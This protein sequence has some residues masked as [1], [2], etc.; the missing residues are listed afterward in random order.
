[1]VDAECGLFVAAAVATTVDGVGTAGNDGGGVVH[2]TG[3]RVDSMWRNAASVTLFRWTDVDGC[4]SNAK[5]CQ[6][7]VSST[8][9]YFYCCCCCGKSGTTILRQSRA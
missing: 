1:M 7:W 4:A 6:A 3:M 9:G 8:G 2:G 5:D